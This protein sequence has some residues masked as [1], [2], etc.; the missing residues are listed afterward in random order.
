MAG[1]KGDLEECKPKRSMPNE[2]NDID[3][4]GLP[5]LKVT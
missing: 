2:V 5:F 3:L 4:F 1:L